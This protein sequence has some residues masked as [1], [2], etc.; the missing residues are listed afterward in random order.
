MKTVKEMAEF[1]SKKRTGNEPEPR[2]AFENL[3]ELNASRNMDKKIYPEEE[4][5]DLFDAAILN[6]KPE[7]DPDNS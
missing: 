1:L 4:L 7:E 3:G 6:W 2:I 5:S